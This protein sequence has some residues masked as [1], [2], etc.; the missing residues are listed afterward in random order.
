[1]RLIYIGGHPAVTCPSLF[2]GGAERQGAP[3]EVKDNE[4]ARALIARGDFIEFRPEPAR[5]PVQ[6]T[7][8]A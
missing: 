8:E 1:M 6:T 3:V 7:K 4:A 2:D 5:K